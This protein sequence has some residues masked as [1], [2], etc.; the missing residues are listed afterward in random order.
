MRDEA[1]ILAEL[2]KARQGYHEAAQKEPAPKLAERSATIRALQQELSDLLSAGATV[3]P[4]CGNKPHGMRKT[5]YEIPLP[6]AQP[7][8]V[9]IYEIGCLA[10]LPT[11]I[12]RNP[13]EPQMR[14]EPRIRA[15]SVEEAVRLWNLGE[16]IVMPDI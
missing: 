1:A 12:P 16:R 9:A 14:H 11:I 5:Q 6:G 2:E 15:G 3:C 7:I 13:P 8:T 10:C 4:D